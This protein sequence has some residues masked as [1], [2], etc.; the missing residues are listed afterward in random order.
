MLG[1]VTEETKAGGLGALIGL[2]EID[3]KIV[4][5]LY[6]I[7]KAPEKEAISLLQTRLV[8]LDGDLSDLAGRR[9]PVET[10]M[11][12]LEERI[13][14]TSK[15]IS[16][17]D[18]ALYSGT[19]SAS[20][21]LQAMSHEIDQLK[22]QKSE[23][24]DSELE[25][26]EA[27]EVFDQEASAIDEKQSELTQELA[28]LKT[29]LAVTEAEVAAQVA[30]LQLARAERASLVPAAILATYDS[31]REHEGGVGAAEVVHG[32]CGGCH[33]KL[34]ATEMDRLHHMDPEKPVLCEQCGRILVP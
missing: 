28:S 2:Q 17:I 14:S 20:K 23:L 10:K 6:R 32:A 9:A 22:S 4:Q 7:E 18:K 16:E 13:A 26:M 8:V 5:A 30:E 24:E 12:E 29:A 19:V 3:T 21:D 11:K 33:L 34:S 27:A 25:L 1:I 31:I 15:R